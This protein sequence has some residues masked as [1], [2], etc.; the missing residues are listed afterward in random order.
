[1][2]ALDNT[3][4]LGGQGGAPAL[5]Q[6]RILSLPD[7]QIRRIDSLVGCLA[8][9]VVDL[10]QNYIDDLLPL[11]R[12]LP[13]FLRALNVSNNPAASISSV[14]HMSSLAHL[15]HLFVGGCTFALAA[16][17]A[18]VDLIP[19]FAALI[20]ELVS[21]D[22]VTL[23]SLHRA[24]GRALAASMHP[25]HTMSNDQ[26]LQYMS[27]GLFDAANASSSASASES[28][29]PP[30]VDEEYE[31]ASAAATERRTAPA[32]PAA[33]AAALA[34]TAQPPPAKSVHVL[35]HDITR[36]KQKL[37]SFAPPPAN[38]HPPSSSSS[39]PLHAPLSQLISLST[40]HP[41]SAAHSSSRAVATVPPS[42]LHHSSSVI[43]RT[44]RSFR[45]RQM[46]KSKQRV[47]RA[48]HVDVRSAA[49]KSSS[50]DDLII[51]RLELLEETVAMQ[52]HV[53]K[54]LHATLERAN[55]VPVP[56]ALPVWR[57]VA[58]ASAAA[59]LIQSAWR[60][61]IDREVSQVIRERKRY[62]ALVADSPDARAHQAAVEA[63]AAT[64]AAFVR[65][66]RAED[67]AKWMFLTISSQCVYRLICNMG[68]RMLEL[69]QRL[70]VYE[71]GSQRHVAES[72][73]ASA[74]A[75][76]LD[77]N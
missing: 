4:G 18:R 47:K 16:A 50:G 42:V 75:M 14:R 57:I 8:L 3:R 48:G 30:F 25:L 45:A 52:L 5:L 7:N 34:P 43:S 23:S 49:P 71:N 41:A 26:L 12:A 11:T 17:E 13:Q 76:T 62:H 68:D 31:E 70:G 65:R 29:A 21:V 63:A 56:A 19:L 6:L 24:Q 74:A 10:S 37:A 54:K 59:T 67:S 20:P 39:P 44:W 36:L 55:S 33:A 38:L 27:D 22:S 28:A 64:I 2:N 1:M 53:I 46:L 15:L 66:R 32:P 58:D 60:G 73:R 51:K 35:A 77:S 40:S 69:E 72:T 9:Q 61:H